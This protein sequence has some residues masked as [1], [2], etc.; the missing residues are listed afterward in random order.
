MDFDRN[1]VFPRQ[2]QEPGPQADPGYPPPP[3][4]GYPA[5]QPPVAGYPQAPVPGYPPPPA[6][7][8]PVAQ[9]PVPGYPVGQVPVPG[10]PAAYPAPPAPVPAPAAPGTTVGRAFLASLVWAGVVLVVVF[11]VQGQALSGYALGY[12][13]GRMLPIS[14]ISGLLVRAFFKRKRLAFG[15]LVLASL[16]TFVVSFVVIGAILLA[17][18]Q[19]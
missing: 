19:R 8:Y 4:A 11:V 15:W 13:V 17:G 16:P 14:L 3:G 6:A 12:L 18:Q 5:A 2:P 7:G 9:A 1:T 10:Y